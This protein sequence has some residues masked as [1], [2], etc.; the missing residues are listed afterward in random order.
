MARDHTRINLDIWGD[1]EFR[2]LPVD[3]QNLYWTLWTSP[4]RTYC[5]AHDWRPES[6]RSAPATGPWSASSRPAQCCRS[7]CSCSSMK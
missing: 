2:D 3:A 4:D 1:D 6:S 5:G 7:V